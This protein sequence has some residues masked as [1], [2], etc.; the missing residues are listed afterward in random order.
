VRLLLL[1]AMIAGCACPDYRVSSPTITPAVSC[2]D[3][4]AET[5]RQGG[6]C[7]VAF[8]TGTNRCSEQLVFARQGTEPEL[9]VAPGGAIDLHVPLPAESSGL[10]HA[11][12]VSAMLG[13]QA[14]T[15]E[16]EVAAK[17]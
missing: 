9:T 14:I 4:S 2:I 16:F 12:M 13:A 6:S 8:L 10:P 17:D 11:Y 3:L 15:I 7:A 1:G 5:R